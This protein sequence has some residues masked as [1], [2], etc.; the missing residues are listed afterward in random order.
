MPV[1]GAYIAGVLVALAT[2]FL[3]ALGLSLQKLAHS[4]RGVASRSRR[5]CFCADP[6]WGCGIA[7]MLVSAL[8][9]LAVFALVGQSVASCFAAVTIVWSLVLSY[10]LLGERVTVV[11]C[12]VAALLGIGAVLAVVF[13]SR[14]GGASAVYMSTTDVRAL[15]GRTVVLIVAPVIALI[16]VLCAGGLV[17]LRARRRA[18]SG[19]AAHPVGELR[20]AAS[21]ALLLAGLFSGLT[22]T[23]SRGLVA[24]VS[25]ALKVEARPVTHSAEVYLFLVGLLLSLVGQILAL[26]AGLKLRPS[27]ETVPQYQAAII[28]LGVCFG[29]LFY[30]ESAGHSAASLVGFG[31]GIVVIILGLCLLAFKGDAPRFEPEAVLLSRLI[32]AFLDVHDSHTTL[33]R[34]LSAPV[35]L[36]PVAAPP[37]GRAASVLLVRRSSAAQPRN[38]CLTTAP[39]P[40]FQ[41]SRVPAP[42]PLVAVG[43]RAHPLVRSDALVTIDI[44][45]RSSA[46]SAPHTTSRR[47]RTTLAAAAFARLVKP[48]AGS[49]PPQHLRSSTAPQAPAAASASVSSA[50]RLPVALVQHFSLSPRLLASALRRDARPRTVGAAAALAAF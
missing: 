45:Q 42:L 13:G 35:R 11:D 23:A 10:L 37:T 3:S 32:D 48:A 14:G 9:S 2:T 21:L 7:A 17:A 47:A 30:N 41:P 33:R 5:K 46:Q 19:S 24:L 40:P 4:R 43:A 38:V 39:P 31:S 8:V 34:S 12:G 25:Y 50:V 18:L 36:V 22:G 6:L 20:G 15:F 28:V 26:N 29:F 44:D 16:M 27:T 49:E 1:V